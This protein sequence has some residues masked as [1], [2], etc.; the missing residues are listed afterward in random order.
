MTRRD[1]HHTNK[2]W[3]KR[4]IPN[5]G[6][7]VFQHMQIQTNPSLFTYDDKDL[8]SAKKKIKLS[9]TRNK[10]NHIHFT[11]NKKKVYLWNKSSLIIVCSYLPVSSSTLQVCS[12]ISLGLFKSIDLCIPIYSYPYKSAHILNCLS[13]SI[14]LLFIF[15]SICWYLYI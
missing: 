9:K 8:R 15:I 11:R 4:K 6:G 3:R 2:R 5:R 7:S 10:N 13:I 14:D 1:T 12:Y